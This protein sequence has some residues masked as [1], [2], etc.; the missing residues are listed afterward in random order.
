MPA[1]TLFL[2]PVTQSKQSRSGLKVD[3]KM[4]PRR[5]EGDAVMSCLME[6]LARGSPAMTK[7]CDADSLLPRKVSNVI[8]VFLLEAL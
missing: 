1:R 3:Y 2:Q 4:Y 8:V 7:E 5:Q 6:Q